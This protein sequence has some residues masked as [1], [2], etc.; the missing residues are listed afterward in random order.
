MTQS[1]PGIDL[2]AIEQVAFVVRNL[3][4][5]LEQ[6]VD[7]LGVGPWT[8]YNV[9]EGDIEDGTYRGDPASFAMRY[10]LGTVGDTMIEL[11]EP[12]AGPTIYRD[13]LEDYGA[14]VHHMAYFS[15]TERECRDVVDGF[16]AAGV[17]VIQSGTLYGTE[18]WYFDTTEELG[19]VFETAI[20]RNVE[21]RPYETYPPD[22]D[23]ADL[24]R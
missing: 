1:A 23:R 15:W 12:T 4:R 6:Y 22:A 16:A 24:T 14:G 19:T 8:V 13:H 3:D 2:P 11:I 18:F 9:R 5:A 21:D 20:R 7:L 10:A 17:D